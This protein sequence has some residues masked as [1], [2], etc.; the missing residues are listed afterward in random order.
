MISLP[1]QC[2]DTK[3]NRT[4]QAQRTTDIFMIAQELKCLFARCFLLGCLY[5]KRNCQQQNDCTA[6]L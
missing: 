5:R 4:Q 2:S 3:D 6:G 1:P